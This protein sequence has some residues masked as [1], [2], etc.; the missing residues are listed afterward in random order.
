MFADI[1][2][3]LQI[4]RPGMN[5]KFFAG[6]NVILFGD[7]HQ[8]K[9]VFERSLIVSRGRTMA[10]KSQRNRLG[11]RLYREFTTAV[12]LDQQMRVTDPVWQN[13]LSRMRYGICTDAD[14]AEIRKLELKVI[15]THCATLFLCTQPSSI[16]KLAAGS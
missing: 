10:A 5:D 3:H 6:V 8:N 13:I 12:E 1:S 2:H 9:P 11:H 16:S 14:I 15:S 4:A 7:F